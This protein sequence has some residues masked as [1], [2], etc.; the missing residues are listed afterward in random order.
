MSL[1]IDYC[2]LCFGQY[3]ANDF[4]NHP[5]CHDRDRMLCKECAE[6]AERFAPE[7]NIDVEEKEKHE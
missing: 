4:V 5:D 1:E 2:D 6:R 3:P 7:S